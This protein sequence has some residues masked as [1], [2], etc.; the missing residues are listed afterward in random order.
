MRRLEFEAP[1][2][3]AAMITAVEEFQVSSKYIQLNVMEER[4][5]SVRVE[6]LMTD[7]IKEV[8]SMY[9]NDVLVNFNM[10]F[11]IKVVENDRG[12]VFNIETDNNPILIG[13]DGKTL[14]ALQFLCKQVSYVFSDVP[15]NITIDVGGYKERRI[16][17]LEILATKTA[18]E[19]AK[20]KIEAKLKP[21]NSYERRIVH[22][23]LTEWRDVETISMG[24]EPNRYLVIR[25]V[26]KES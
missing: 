26:K 23:K 19:V 7:D 24:E 2:L 4:Q 6:A 17:Q 22:A 12:Y 14:S 16:L 10:P 11:T 13:R 9:L 5:E 18:K 20:S 25:P 15:Q 3:E 21:M 8:I 1:T